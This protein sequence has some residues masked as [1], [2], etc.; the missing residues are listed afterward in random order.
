M[1]C[2]A[3]RLTPIYYSNI[4]AA[5]FDALRGGRIHS[6]R[7]YR[8]YGSKREAWMALLEAWVRLS[9]EERPQTTE[10]IR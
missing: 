9:P 8:E 1:T 4:P 10:S 7:D 5:L 3:A 6:H 2:P